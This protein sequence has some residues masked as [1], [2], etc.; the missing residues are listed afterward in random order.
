MYLK[1]GL[2]ENVN[3]Y[4]RKERC[5]IICLNL[6]LKKLEQEEQN[7]DKAS[8]KKKKTEKENQTEKKK[9]GKSTRYQWNDKQN[10]RGNQWSQKMV[11]WKEQQIW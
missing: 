6:C 8:Q 2:E 11:L 3:T 10:N 7:Q 1:Q 4:I 5:Q 9:Q